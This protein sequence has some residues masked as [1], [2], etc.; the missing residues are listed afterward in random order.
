[1]KKFSIT[2]ESIAIKHLL[3]AL[4]DPACGAVST[5][6]G[7]VRKHNKK[8]E[9]I[10]LHYESYETLCL[11]EGQQI[12]NEALDHFEITNALCVHRIGALEIGDLAIWIGVSAP[13]RDASFKACRYIIDEVKIRLPIWKKELYVDGDSGWL[14]G[15]G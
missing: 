7:R 2:N 8:R 6:E 11:K 5:F 3:V 14:E 13:H 15:A 12:V 1:M 9:V 4:E 10:G